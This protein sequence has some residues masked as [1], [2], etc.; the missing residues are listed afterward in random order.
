[1]LISLRLHRVVPVFVGGTGRSGTTVV[2]DLL[3]NHSKIR[4]STPIEIKFL[5]NRSGLVDVVFGYNQ[6]IEKKPESISILNFR[7]YR[8]RKQREEERFAKIF[9]EFKKFIWEKWWDIDAP[10][11][12]GR[13]LTSGIAKTDLQRLLKRLERDLRINR[14]WAARR[15]MAAFIKKQ[16]EAGDEIYW[17]ETTPMNIP[18]AGKLQELFPK[19]LFI[20]MVRDPR[21]V[22]ASLLTKNWGPTSPLEGLDWIEK[23]LVAGHEAL[24]AIEPKKRVT[25]ALED[26][27]I[28]NRDVTYKKLQDFLKISDEPAMQD[29]FTKSMTPGAATSGRWKEEIDSAEFSAG[30]EAMVGRLKSNG[31]I[32]Q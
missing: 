9:A 7:T 19:A 6:Y 27:V 15:F 30:Y 3:G 22:I 2:G 18:E 14:K 28:K 11:P 17:I 29:F 5:T 10:P 8:K 24:T 20:N 1:M 23:R 4:T 25:I 12:H 13:G 31:I 32:F 26:L 16:F 21:D